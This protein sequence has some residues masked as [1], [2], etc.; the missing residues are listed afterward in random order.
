MGTDARIAL[1]TG[2]NKGIGLEVARG[3]GRRGVVVYLG[4]RQPAL[5]SAA[6]AVLSGEG[7]DVRFL[8]L[9]VTDEALVEAARERIDD[10]HGRLDILVN[11]AGTGLDFTPPSELPLKAFR[12]TS[13]PTSSAPCG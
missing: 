11:N 5:G 10:D 8:H 12:D 9:D 6:A 7:L 2:A 4:A 1:V 13:R 3:L